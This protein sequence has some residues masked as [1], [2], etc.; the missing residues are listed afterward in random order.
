M[1]KKKILLTSLLLSVGI[2]TFAIASP[3]VQAWFI[4]NRTTL[5]V[6]QN[7]GSGDI[8]TIVDADNAHSAYTSMGL[9]ASSKLTAPTS[10]QLTANHSN[11]TP[12]L[13]SGIIFMSGHGN[14]SQIG[15]TNV[16]VRNDATDS[17]KYI[18]IGKYQNHRTALWV[19]AACQTASGSS[20]ITKYAADQGAKSSIG[21]VPSIGAGSHTNWLKRFNGQIKTKTKTVAQSASSASG[22]IYLDNGVKNYKIYGYTTYNPWYFMNAAEKGSTSYELDSDEYIIENNILAKNEVVSETEIKKSAENF[23]KNNINKNFNLKDYKV[24]INGTDEKYYDYVLHVDGIRTNIGYTVVAEVSGQ[25]R[26]YDNT[27]NYIIAQV[28]NSIQTVSHKATQSSANI[29]RTNSMQ[30]AISNDLTAQN[31]KVHLETA[32]YDVFTNRLYN[33][34]FV[35]VETSEGLFY[36]NEYLTEIK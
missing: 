19:F 26:I 34:V 23:I 27:E 6:G 17:G 16:G 12:R 35:E 11:G 29:A 25:V 36:V 4:P 30:T 24:E 20:N 8:N 10:S 7:Y 1:K 21:W 14:A 5:S 31:Y 13:E 2:I 33:A 28:K 32:Y 18:G 3:T 9:N 22:W 15:F